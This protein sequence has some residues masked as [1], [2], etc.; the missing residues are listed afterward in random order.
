MVCRLNSVSRHVQVNLQ[1]SNLRFLL[2]HSISTLKSPTRL[3]QRPGELREAVAWLFQVLG[4]RTARVLLRWTA[5]SLKALCRT[6]M[7]PD[8]ELELD[9]DCRAAVIPAPIQRPGAQ[10]F[11]SFDSDAPRCTSSVSKATAGAHSK[12]FELESS[13]ASGR[14]QPVARSSSFIIRIG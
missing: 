7:M 3:T 8:S 6:R 10:I 4:L 2:D 14:P 9:S 12:S 5:G 1:T 11:M 13:R